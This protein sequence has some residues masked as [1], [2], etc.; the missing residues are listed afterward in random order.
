MTD[1]AVV[2]RYE[3]RHV[4]YVQ[5]ESPEEAATAALAEELPYGGLARLEVMTRAEAECVL[6]RSY[7]AE[8]GLLLEQ[9]DLKI[10]R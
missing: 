9:R 3:K 7:D 8:T 6:T 1:Y 4:V 5:A 10:G 2:L